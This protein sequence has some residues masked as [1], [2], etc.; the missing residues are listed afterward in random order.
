MA[1]SATLSPEGRMKGAETCKNHNFLTSSPADS[2]D[3]F[4]GCNY[5]T[6]AQV[7]RPVEPFIP[8]F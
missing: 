5:R 6:P 1:G 3:V 2:D 4:L 8:D 7:M